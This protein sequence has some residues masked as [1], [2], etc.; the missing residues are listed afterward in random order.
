MDGLMEEIMTNLYWVLLIVAVLVQVSIAAFAVFHTLWSKND[1]ID[2]VVAFDLSST[3]V[4]STLVLIAIWERDLKFLDLAI[5][6]AALG[7]F[8][9]I[10]LARYIVDHKI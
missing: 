1:N 7:Y 6:L 4:V 8:S 10:V 3:L 5:V 9:S 2:R